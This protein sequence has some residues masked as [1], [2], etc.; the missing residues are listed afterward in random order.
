MVGG[1][2]KWVLDG[3][4]ELEDDAG[5]AKRG[6][7]RADRDVPAIACVAMGLTLMMGAMVLSVVCR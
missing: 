3:H 6:H 5:R 2:R 7:M 1:L 4:V